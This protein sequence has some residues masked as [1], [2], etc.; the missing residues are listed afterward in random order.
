[1][2]ELTV[3]KRSNIRR[4]PKILWPAGVVYREV[5][6]ALVK[7]KPPYDH[8]GVTTVHQTHFLETPR[9]QRAYARAVKAGGWD[10][11]IPYRIHQALWCSKIAQRVPGDFVE[12]GTGRGFVMS[13]LLE[14]GLSRPLHLFDTFLP[15]RLND[16]GEQTEDD[17]SP[18]YA[19]SFEPV[20]R[21]FAEWPNV[22][23]HAGNLYETLPAAKLSQVAFAHIDMN[24]PDPEEFGVRQ[25]W[26]LMPAGAVL[27]F[28][29][30]AF[31]DCE[32]QR[33]RIDAL[34]SDLGFDVLT[35]ASGQGI[36]IKG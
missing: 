28:D 13:A 6:N 16:A 15:N 36:V 24:H 19:E 12:L 33:E 4:Y 34:G 10:Y 11:G 32:R 9:F 20:K 35:T 14:D 5:K 18:H 25:L 27:L 31:R 30:Y 2:V 3:G 8:D 22:V 29:D 26:P 1:V 7:P 23:F 21:N 17:L